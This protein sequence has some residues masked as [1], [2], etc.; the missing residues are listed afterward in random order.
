MWKCHL[1]DEEGGEA[2]NSL[3]LHNGSLL[4]QANHLQLPKGLIE[5]IKKLNQNMCSEK[6]GKW[7]IFKED[8]R[9]LLLQLGYVE[10]GDGE[11]FFRIHDVLPLKIC[12]TLL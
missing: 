9:S 3:L 2:K 1:V 6:N 5:R 7:I 8:I 11:S 12:C 4:L 10:L